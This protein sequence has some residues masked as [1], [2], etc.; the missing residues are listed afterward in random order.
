MDNEEA[1]EMLF[2]M[3]KVPGLLRIITN[4]CVSPNCKGGEHDTSKYPLTDPR[5]F[6]IHKVVNLEELPNGRIR[7]DSAEGDWTYGY[8]EAVLR[9]LQEWNMGK[10]IAE[11]PQGKSGVF[12]RLFR[13]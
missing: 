8:P 5:H 10:I 6:V 2:N 7:A 9:R 1:K 12:S 11:A 13:H 3:L 4:E